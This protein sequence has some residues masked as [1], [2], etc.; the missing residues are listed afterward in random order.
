MKL[1]C[2]VF[3][4]TKKNNNNN[5]FLKS[6]FENLSPQKKQWENCLQFFPGSNPASQNHPFYLY[7]NMKGLKDE[8]RKP[9]L[10][11]VVLWDII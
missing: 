9:F 8:K 1:A 6:V 4:E 5:Q 3:V 2:I 10:V 7:N 11:I